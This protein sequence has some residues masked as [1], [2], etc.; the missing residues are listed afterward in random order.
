MDIFFIVLSFAGSL[1]P[2]LTHV[3]GGKEKLTVTFFSSSLGEDSKKMQDSPSFIVT[4]W[5]PSEA[6]LK[7]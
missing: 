1:L 6:H 2:L 3:W 5:L 4:W 7:I